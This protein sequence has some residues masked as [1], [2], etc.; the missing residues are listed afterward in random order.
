MSL[1]TGAH[2]Y[3]ILGTV[4]GFSEG[5]R[6]CLQAWLVAGLASA[7]PERR[8][9]RICPSVSLIP[10]FKWGHWPG[11]GTWVSGETGSPLSAEMCLSLAVDL[12]SFV[13]HFE[14]DMAKY[15]AKQPLVSVVDT[16]AKVRGGSSLQ[17]GYLSVTLTVWGHWGGIYMAFGPRQSR[18]ALPRMPEAGGGVGF[19]AP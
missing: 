7:L 11:H 9:P 14:W 15:P 1:D 18:E 5:L 6:S 8:E 17:P 16:L 12:T 4:V 10:W 2:P 19:R 13:T 3:S